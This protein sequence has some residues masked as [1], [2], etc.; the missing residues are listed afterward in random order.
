MT[1]SE[2]K[3]EGISNLSLYIYIYSC[4]PASWSSGQR[5]RLLIMKSRVWFPALPWDF[6]LIGEDSHG[7][8]GLGLRPLPVLHIHISPSTS[9]GQC[10]RASWGSQPRK[11]VKSQP[12][13]GGETTKSMTDILWHWKKKKKKKKKK[14]H[15]VVTDWHFLYFMFSTNTNRLLPGWNEIH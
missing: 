10:N 4:R 15:I 11:S 5:F 1:Y 7:D 8:H 2:S 13:P 14:I 6:S 12:Q 9:S 3:H